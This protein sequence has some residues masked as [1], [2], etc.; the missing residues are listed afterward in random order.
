MSSMRKTLIAALLLTACQQETARMTQDTP[1]QTEAPAQTVT[2]AQATSP[3]SDIPERQIGGAAAPMQA[4]QL[5]EYSIRMPQTLTA[6]KQSFHV[7]N[8]GKE[9]HSFEIEGNGVH[10]RLPTDLS[11]GSES[12]LD[13][14][15][16]PGTYTVYCPIKGHKERGMTTTITVQ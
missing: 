8:N 12:H 6:G 4:V 15:L 14:D 5:I 16:K 10:S 11:A 2:S 7:V 9:L 1:R 3:Q 13:V